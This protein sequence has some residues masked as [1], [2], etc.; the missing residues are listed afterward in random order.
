[1]KIN[2]QTIMNSNW[3][4]KMFSSRQ[5]GE[6]AAAAASRQPAAPMELGA[7]RPLSASVNVNVKPTAASGRVASQSSGAKF[8]KST[9]V[10]SPNARRSLPLLT[11]GERGCSC[12][13]SKRPP[14]GPNFSGRGINKLAAG[15]ARGSACAKGGNLSSLAKQ[16]KL[17]RP[18]RAGGEQIG[19][20]RAEAG[21]PQPVVGLFCLA[22]GALINAHADLIGRRFIMWPAGARQTRGSRRAAPA[23]RLHC[24]SAPA[25]QV[26]SL[27]S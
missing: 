3:T 10:T 22:E 14:L 26:R 18:T 17:A 13:R 7:W 5:K 8:Q 15:P 12:G 21:R 11:L 25:P 27:R 2:W 23:R 19:E 1:M 4:I 24:A 9:D 6:L 20:R 16:A